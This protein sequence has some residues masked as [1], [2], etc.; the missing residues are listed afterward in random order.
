MGRFTSQDPIGLLGGDNLYAYAPNPVAWV[1]PLGLAKCGIGR[2]GRQERL[3]E[4]LNDPKL[5]KADKGW[6]QQE[7]NQIN[8]GKRKSIR[9]PSSSKRRT[10]NGVKYGGSGGKELAHKRGFEAAKGYGYEHSNLQDKDLHKLQHK[11]DD[12]GR[13]NKD[14]GLKDD[15]P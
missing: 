7:I 1:D 3:R 2:S 15:C 10:L 11:Y 6:I 5:G 14:R 12:K 4:L 13:K 8:R 9:L